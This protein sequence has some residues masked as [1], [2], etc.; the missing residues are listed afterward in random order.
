MTHNVRRIGLYLALF[1]L[2][3]GMALAQTATVTGNITDEEGEP[4][5]GAN[6]LIEELV[7]GGSTDLNGRYS[8]EVPTAQTQGQTVTLQAGYVGYSPVSRQITLDPGEQTQDFVLASDLF[9]LDE[10]V[11][12]GVTEATPAKKLAFTVERLDAKLLE[13]VPASSA[14]GSLQG[15]VA[16]AQVLQTS[17]Q[18]GDGFSVRL[19]GTTSLSGSSAPLYIVDG[20]ILGAN[21]VDFSALDI[22]NMEIV[23]GAAASS[24]YGARAQNGVIQITTKRGSNVP[25]NQTRVTFRNELSVNSMDNLV[26]PSQSHSFLQNG[27]GEF[28]DADGNVVGYADAVLDEVRPGIQFQ[29][30]AYFGETFNALEQFFDPGT[31]YT[32]YISISQN[33]AKTNFHASFENLDEAGTVKFTNGYQRQSFNVNLDHRISEK[34]S[35]SSTMKYSRSETDRVSNNDAAD[36]FFGLMFTSPLSNL[37]ARDVD[38]VD[39]DGNTTELIIQ[40]DP[41]SVEENP[42]YAL[43][44]AETIDR[45]SRVLTN[46]RL[47]YQ[48]LT[49]LTLDGTASYDRSDRDGREFYDRGYDAIGGNSSVRDGRIVSNTAVGEAFNADVTGSVRRTFGDLTAR[50]QVKYQVELFDQ[51][52]EFTR[53]TG[54]GA[55]GIPDFSN[56]VAD[57]TNVSSTTQTVRSEGYFLTAGIDFKDR[58]IADFLVRRDGSSLFGADE[59][60]HTYYRLSA[61]Y[62][63]SEEEWWPLAD[64]MDEFKVRYSIGTAGARPSFSAQYETYSLS[65]GQISKN[66]LGNV[67]L[68]PELSTEQEFGLEFSLGGRVFIDAVY[69]D[70]RVEDQLLQVPL[71]GYT[72]FN[73]QWRNAGVIESNTFELS[74]EAPVIEQRDLSLRVG[75]VF[76]RTRQEIVE[77]ESNPTP[78]GPLSVFFYGAGEIIGA[79]Y[80]ND[81]IREASQL[82]EGVNPAA[83]DVNDDG[84]LVPVGV[85]FTAED[86]ITED[87]WGTLVDVDGDGAGDAAYRYGIPVRFVDENGETFTQIGD[88]LPDFNLGFNTTF[89]YKGLTVYG[90]VSAQ[91]GGDI[92]NRTK[93]HSFREQQNVEF[94]QSGVSDALKKPTLYHDVL[95]DA[96]VVNSHFVE[97]GDFIKLR[98]LAVSYRFGRQDLQKI[99]GNALNSVSVSLVG[100]NLFTFTDYSG[101]DPEVGTGN[102]ATLFRVD[103][104][105]YPT[106]RTFT[107]RLEIQF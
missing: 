11:V 24:L 3:P 45:R 62:R 76:D 34:L 75:G 49:W 43:E 67:N 30:N 40:P 82:P 36:P 16:G 27:A 37:E 78:T 52:T 26:L 98:E 15:K 107:G 56:I 92:Y 18:P 19:R 93:Q 99:F 104:F 58:Y 12:T 8:F 70:T 79:M 9:D 48:P 90:L 89:T 73:T 96:N 65:A 86:G 29:D 54:L 95:Y 2:L 39:G 46:F 20:V 33:S 77:Y 64:V 41:R 14:M 32:N 72:G 60:W 106:Y 13:Q 83:F 101:F 10:V 5:I 105:N 61:A 66:T 57:G 47:R 44:N 71:P 28:I 6:V 35:V 7:I 22:E 85:G 50:A 84:Y 102:D 55:A 97:D 4:L 94:D 1:L 100:R 80:G 53:G 87:L 42:L 91:I 88:V 63:V 103:N 21:Q 31:S 23:K 25:L 51:D 17:G 69:A 68:T 59:R 81:W 74:I 38:D